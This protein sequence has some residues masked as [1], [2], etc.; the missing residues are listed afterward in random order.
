M[1]L[2]KFQKCVILTKQQSVK[3]LMKKADLQKLKSLLVKKGIRPSIQRVKILEYLM[4]SEDHPTAD[5]VFST[6]SKDIPTLSKTTVFTTLKLFHQKGLVSRLL[7]DGTE[8]RYDAR[9]TPHPHFRCIRCGKVYDV[10][11]E[12]RLDDI[13]SLDGHKVLECHVYFLGICRDCLNKE[14]SS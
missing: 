13:K 8:M 7:I 9:T 4:N 6:I 11:F 5:M 12:C 3:L 14:K 10:P 1:G 2:Q